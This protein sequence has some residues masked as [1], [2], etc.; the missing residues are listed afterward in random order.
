MGEIQQASTVGGA[1]LEP[2]DQGLCVGGGYVMEFINN[3][4]AIYDKN[5]SQLLAPVGSA[6]VFDQPTTDFFSDPRLLR[7]P[8]QALVPAG[9]HRRHG[10][11]GWR[12]GDPERPV[13]GRQQHPGPHRHLH[14]L[15]VGHH[16]RRHRATAPASVTTTTWAPRQRHLR[17]HRPVRHRLGLQRRGHLRHLQGA[18]GERGADRDRPAGVRLPDHPRPVR[19]AGDHRPCQH[20]TWREVRPWH[21]VLRRIHPDQPSDNHVQVYAMNDT[22]Q[23]NAVS[24]GPPA[25]CAPP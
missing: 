5:G 22:S 7:R 13:R 20:A 25:C 18:A 3:A 2:P 14:R 15:L 16:R 12:R 9:V 19:P 11:L 1:D 8:D 4:L 23:L 17:R 10:R 21:R 24:S 6:Q